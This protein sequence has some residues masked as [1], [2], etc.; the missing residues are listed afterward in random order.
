MLEE[1]AFGAM[2]SR[3]DYC[4]ATVAFT[5]AK[6]RVWEHALVPPVGKLSAKEEHAKNCET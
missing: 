1:K 5:A 6:R 2:L 3:A 4:K